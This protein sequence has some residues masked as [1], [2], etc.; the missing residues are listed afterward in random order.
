MN[1]NNIFRLRG[2]FLLVMFFLMGSVLM[3]SPAEA[4]LFSISLREKKEA[5]QKAVE[6]KQEP[7]RQTQQK[8]ARKEKTGYSVSEDNIKLQVVKVAAD[9]E[10]SIKR[11]KGGEYTL[12]K[13][14]VIAIEVRR[15]EEFSGIFPLSSDG[16]IQ[17][18]FVGDIELD[19][20][21]KSEAEEKISGLLSKYIENPE[22]NITITQYNSKVVYVL[23][24]VPSPGRYVMRG[25]YLP[26]RDA[27]L[28]A[29]LPLRNIAAMRRTLI[30]RPVADGEIVVKRVNIL[31]LLYH[32]N[33]A[34]N[35]DLR[36]GDIVYVPSTVLYKVGTVLDQIISPLFRGAVVY[37]TA[38][39]LT[40][41]ED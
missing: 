18:N 31:S 26:L 10:Q 25:Q 22:V 41:N 14:D 12:G 23:G 8:A 3:P 36:S 4:Q 17:Y 40:D 35:Y 38:D 5:E 28:N 24:E 16:K 21:T 37:Q 33:L 30:I 6:Q 20:L 15:H 2:M 11:E 7:T 1:S 13:D 29:G 27:L 39:E 9:S 34:L 32:G 19:G